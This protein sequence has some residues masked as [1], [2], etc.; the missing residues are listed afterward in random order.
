[1]NETHPTTIGDN[2]TVGHAALLH[3][4]TIEDRCL[5]GMGAILLNGAH[6]GTESIVAAG[7]LLVEGHE[8][9]AALAG[10]GQPRQGEADAHRR[11]GR[12]ASRRTPTATS[13]TVSTTWTARIAAFR[14]VAASMSTKPPSGTRDFLPDDI[15]RREYV[16]GVVRARLR[17]LRLR[18]ARD[19]G[20]REHRDAARQV[21]R[22]GQQAHFQDPAS[23]ASTRRAAKPTSRCA[24]T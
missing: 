7:T 21:R 1:M 4:C 23:A 12:R 11:R 20:V 17:A 24:T 15:R 9:A 2:V 22:R 6:I 14:S 18:A 3:G 10:D 19:A 5:I 16:I 8:G 13:A